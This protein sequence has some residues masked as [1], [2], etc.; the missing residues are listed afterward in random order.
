M[1]EDFFAQIKSCVLA[2]TQEQFDT[3][4]RQYMEYRDSVYDA[5]YNSTEAEVNSYYARRKKGETV[6]TMSKAAYEEIFNE[7][8]WED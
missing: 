1:K 8:P 3:A 6:V 4:Y 2:V 7:R 5:E